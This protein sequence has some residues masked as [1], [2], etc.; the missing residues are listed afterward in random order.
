MES[1]KSPVEPFECADLDTPVKRPFDV[2][3]VLANLGKRAALFDER[4]RLPVSLPGRLSLL[5]GGVLEEALLSQHL[6]KPD[7][8]CPAE[9]R[10]CAIC[11]DYFRTLRRD[12]IS[13]RVGSRH[14]HS[15]ADNY[16]RCCQ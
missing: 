8:P 4:N 1:L 5:E 3:E 2:W 15:P 16:S 14:R 6:I 9:I 10:A 7:V 13:R 11:A 12:G